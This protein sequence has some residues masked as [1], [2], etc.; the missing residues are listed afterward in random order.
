L[1]G[2]EGGAGFWQR[3]SGTLSDDG[4]SIRGAWEK[5]PDGSSWEHDLDVI[6]ARVGT[7]RN[8]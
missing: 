3:F 6:Y 5:S 4:D 8:R 7:S 1:E 2:V